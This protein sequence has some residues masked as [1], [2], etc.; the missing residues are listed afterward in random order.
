MTRPRFVIVLVYMFSS[1]EY[2]K[3][4]GAAVWAGFLRRFI[5]PAADGALCFGDMAFDETTETTS[6]K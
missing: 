6:G 2:G 1:T 5:P 4:R 3:L